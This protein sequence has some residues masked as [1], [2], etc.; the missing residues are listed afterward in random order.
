MRPTTLSVVKRDEMTP[1]EQVA[2]SKAWKAE[3]RSTPEGETEY[4]EMRQRAIDAA[5]Q[6]AARRSA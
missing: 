3:L 1:E 6:L 4:Q 5:E 2:R